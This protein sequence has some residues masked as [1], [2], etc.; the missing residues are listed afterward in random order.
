MLEKAVG[1]LLPYVC[2]PGAAREQ[3]G[4]RAAWKGCPGPEGQEDVPF[5]VQ[6]AAVLVTR[7]RVGTLVPREPVHG[8]T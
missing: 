5:Q 8:G 1:S 4:S 2:G 7:A 3:E 6:T